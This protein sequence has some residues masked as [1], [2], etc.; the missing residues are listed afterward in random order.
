MNIPDLKK[1][2]EY[3][4]FAKMNFLNEYSG[5]SVELKIELSH[6]WLDSMKKCIFCFQNVLARAR[7]CI[8]QMRM[9]E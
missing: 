5:F 2:N 4:V 6:F 9:T 7:H 8:I 3:S 1:L